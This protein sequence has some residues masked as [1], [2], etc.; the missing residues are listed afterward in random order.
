M[1]KKSIYGLTFDD[2]TEWF[3]DKGQKK[4]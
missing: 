4:I 2:L 1:T 3:L